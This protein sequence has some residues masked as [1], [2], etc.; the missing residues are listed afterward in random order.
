[1]A[2]KSKGGLLSGR[3]RHTCLHTDIHMYITFIFSYHICVLVKVLVQ[4]SGK[5]SLALSTRKSRVHRKILLWYSEHVSKSQAVMVD[6]W[7]HT[8]K[9][10]L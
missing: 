9:R 4:V 5:S 2:V 8:V 6:G 7:G 3:L 1:M 10:Y